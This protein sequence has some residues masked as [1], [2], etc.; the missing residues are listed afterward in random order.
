MD[1][2]SRGLNQAQ[3]GYS[4]L[5][6]LQVRS[7]SVFSAETTNGDSKTTKGIIVLSY[8]FKGKIAPC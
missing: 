3:V 6:V 4:D 2:I 5:T 8:C 1:S 7:K